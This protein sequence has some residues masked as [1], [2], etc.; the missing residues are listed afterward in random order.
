MCFDKEDY[1]KET[2]IGQVKYPEAGF[3][4]IRGKEQDCFYFLLME[5]SDVSNID[6]LTGK[7]NSC[8]PKAFQP[9]HFLG[10]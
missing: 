6:M 4:L 5:S 9:V 2:F 1:A 7:N 10:N 3:V 8:S